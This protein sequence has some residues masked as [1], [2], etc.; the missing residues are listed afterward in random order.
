MA[1]KDVT[2]LLLIHFETHGAIAMNEE[3][4]N[5]R[6]S[7]LKE[8]VF[9]HPIKDMIIISE[10]LNPHNHPRLTQLKKQITSDYNPRLLKHPRKKLANRYVWIEL[11]ENGLTPTQDFIDWIKFE[12]GNVHGCNIVNI[13]ATGQNLSGCVWNSLDYSALSWAKRGHLVQ[14]IL[15]MCGDYEMSGTGIEKYMK[16]FAQL[17]QKI[18]FSGNIQNIG[19]VADIDN[20]RYMNDGKRIRGKQDLTNI[21]TSL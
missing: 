17:Y 8:L 14:I 9:E 13:L 15:S 7:K 11:T 20:I 16:S 4:D 12:A 2:A 21:L 19:L 6:F 1:L 18:R 10:K 5:M 3:L